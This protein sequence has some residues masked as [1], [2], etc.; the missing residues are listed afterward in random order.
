MTN[1]PLITFV[2]TDDKPV[3]IENITLEIA[4]HFK[5][6]RFY[7]PQFCRLISTSKRWKVENWRPQFDQ[8]KSVFSKINP[9]ETRK[10]ID[11]ID[12]GFDSCTTNLEIDDLRGCMLEAL[13]MGSY[14]GRKVISNPSFGWGSRVDL[15]MESGKTLK[16]KFECLNTEQPLCVRRSTVDFGYWNKKHGKFYE[17]KVQ[18]IS[19][20]C[21]EINYMRTLRKELILN[22]ISNEV[23][24][25]FAAS[26]DKVNMDLKKLQLESF[27]KPLGYE[28]ISEMISA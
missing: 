2:R 24:F 20:T 11:I 14:G 23:F 9:N 16:V 22:K 4:E 26:K 7:V 21:K 27:F 19:L 17:C 15:N 3:H 6:S 12:R 18:P 13:I 25:A 1:T 8:W 10:I 5:V 28:D